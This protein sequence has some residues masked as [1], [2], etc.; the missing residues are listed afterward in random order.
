MSDQLLVH[1][2]TPTASG[3]NMAK[4]GRLPSVHN[5]CVTQPFTAPAKVAS[6]NMGHRSK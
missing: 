3:G 2:F 6:C 1:A 4:S 5:R